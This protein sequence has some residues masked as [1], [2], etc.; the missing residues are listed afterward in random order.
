MSKESNTYFPSLNNIK[1]AADTIKNVSAVT[2]L[3]VSLRY[4]EF[5]GRFDG[6]GTPGISYY[7]VKKRLKMNIMSLPVHTV[8]KMNSAPYIIAKLALY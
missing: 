5:F 2:P 3:G 6:T 7:V 8:E 4:S 1:L